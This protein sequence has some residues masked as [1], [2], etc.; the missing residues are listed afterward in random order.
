MADIR[1]EF[2]SEGFREILN[3]EGCHDLVQQ[4][5]EGIAERANAN[6]GL[7][8]FEATSVKAGTRWIAFASTTDK[9]SLIAE[10]ED[11]ALTGAIT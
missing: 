10:S 8:T 9:D 3:S 1:I 4:T 2:I 6:A 5:A 7:T 11:K